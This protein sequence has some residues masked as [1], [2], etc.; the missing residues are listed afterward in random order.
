MQGASGVAQLHLFAIN[1]SA[2]YQTYPQTAAAFYASNTAY[3]AGAGAA[4]L[5]AGGKGNFAP[6]NTYNNGQWSSAIALDVD[7]ACGQC[8]GGG[9]GNGTNPYG[10]KLPVPAPPTFTRAFLAQAATNIHYIANI[11]TSETPV[12]TPAAGTYVATQTVA[13]SGMAGAVLHYTTD[14][15]TPTAASTQYTGPI[16]VSATTIIKAIAV[17]PAGFSTSPVTTGVFTI[18]AAGGTVATPSIAPSTG[19]FEQSSNGFLLTIADATAGA[20]ICY[21]T[22]GTAPTV[23]SGACGNGTLYSVAFTVIPTVT[24]KAIAFA[25]GMTNSAVASNTFTAAT[26]TPTFSI[27]S[28]QFNTTQSLYILDLTPN[29]VICYT[30]STTTTAPAAPTIAGTLAAPACGAGS[31]QFSIASPV[32][33]SPGSE[34]QIKAI[35]AAS[36]FASSAVTSTN[37]YNAT[38]PTPSFNTLGTGSYYGSQWITIL[39]LDGSATICFQALSTTAT[40]PTV[41]PAKT[42][43]SGAWSA[44]SGPISVAATGKIYAYAWDGTLNNSA[45]ANAT[46]TINTATA[47]PAF[48]VPPGTYGGGQQLVLSDATPGALICYTTGATQPV[49]TAGTPP[50]CATGTAYSSAIAIPAFIAVTVNAIAAGPNNMTP[51]AVVTASYNPVPPSVPVITPGISEL[52]HGPQQITMTDKTAGAAIYYT[53]ATPGVSAPVL[54]TVASV[55]Y[56]GT[57]TVS[58]PTTFEAVAALGSA[59]AGYAYSTPVQVTVNVVPLAPTILPAGGVFAAAPTVTLTNRSYT[60]NLAVPP[61]ATIC[62]TTDGSTPVVTGA[63]ACGGSGVAYTN[64]IKIGSSMT[65]KAIASFGAGS[66]SSVTS[67]VFTLR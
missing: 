29:A 42:G 41:P 13:L 34:L 53:A 22:N 27:S 24:V 11:E 12:F 8:H 5:V 15:T 25:S 7:I 65:L 6:M 67:A 35:A 40:A 28:G 37:T 62:Y 61:V 46:Y 57:F 26:L 30:T 36:G 52:V 4:F 54:P 32:T 21:T 47:N 10:I 16:T 56:S 44:Y 48:S 3:N 43:C 55:A 18:S 63:G 9:S 60:T 39:D 1:P 14:G 51:S 19:N 33:I 31:T 59:A 23:S 58:A 50:V 49:V 45:L 17:G 66:T 20:S 2:S 64:P 38:V